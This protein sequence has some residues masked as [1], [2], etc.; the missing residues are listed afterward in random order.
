[1]PNNAPQ[2][3]RPT[4]RGFSPRPSWAGSLAASHALMNFVV[5]ICTA[6]LL[7][8]SSGCMTSTV[9]RDARNPKPTDAA[10]W[11]NYLLLPITVLADIATSSVQIPAYIAAMRGCPPRHFA[12]VTNT[13]M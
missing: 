1:M 12:T 7:L 8:S 2:R 11:A 10:P 6:A 13:N 3:A 4:R 5:L 9:I